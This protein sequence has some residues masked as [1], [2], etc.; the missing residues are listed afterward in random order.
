MLGGLLILFAISVLIVSRGKLSKDSSTK[1]VG[2]GRSRPVSVRRKPNQQKHQ[3]FK[4]EDEPQEYDNGQTALNEQDAERS[5][6]IRNR[7][8]TPR[9]KRLNTSPMKKRG[10][11]SSRSKSKTPSPDRART[12]PVTR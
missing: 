1:T 7:M 10:S 6:R 8:K 9:A 4:E 2:S 12:M 5:D 11:R 3:T